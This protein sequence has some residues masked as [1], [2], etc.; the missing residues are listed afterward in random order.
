MKTLRDP[1]NTNSTTIAEALMTYFRLISSSNVTLTSNNTITIDEI[2]RIIANL[3]GTSFVGNSSSS[4]IIIQPVQQGNKLVLG[5][6]ATGIG[7][8][9]IIDTLNQETITNSIISTAAI[10]SS[11]PLAGV[12]YLSMLIINNPIQYRHIGNSA[13][14]TLVSSVIVV[15]VQR[16]PN[17]T[18]QSMN[19]SLF[20][21]VLDEFKPN[22][23]NVDYYCSFYDTNNSQWNESGCTTPIYNHQWN[24][25]EC[26][27]NHLTSFALVASPQ[28]ANVTT[29]PTSTT[30]TPSP[31]QVCVNATHTLLSNGTCV[32]SVDA[33]V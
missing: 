12:I 11:E 6:L 30:T 32:L 33:T 19:I 24:R 7:I 9:A 1:N 26:N 4:Y 15:A 13:N 3:N 14:K 2:D 16:D 22:T 27:C 25:Y 23:T 18:Q 28:T 31:S 5:A 17:I 10:I 29:E 21:Q 8:G 20:F